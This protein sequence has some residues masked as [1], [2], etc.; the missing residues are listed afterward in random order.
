MRDEEE[1]RARFENRARR[2]SRN[3]PRG[4]FDFINSIRRK[5]LRHRRAFNSSLLHGIGDDAAVIEQ[6]GGFDTVVTADLLVEDVDFRL[7]TTTARHLGHKALAVSLSDIAAMGA[8]PRFAL[9]SVGVPRFIWQSKF[10]DEFY[11]G[12]FALAHHYRVGL[13]GGDVSRTPGRVVIDSI[14]IGEVEHGSAVTR[15]GAR[16]GDHIFVTGNLGGATAGLRLLENETAPGGRR[17]IER[18]IGRHRRPEPRLQWGALLGEERLATAMIDLSDGLS[19]DLAHLCRE[20]RV[21]ARIDAARIPVD[22]VVEHLAGE[23]RLHPL[24]AALGGGEDFELLF[25]IRP[26]DLSRLPLRLGNV[27]ATYIG[28][29]TTERDG[30]LLNQGRSLRRLTPRGFMHF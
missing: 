14:V 3:P 18:A 2:S 8:R 20:S 1:D 12:F 4:E 10:L 6:R 19:S 5:A 27:P 30:V 7:S 24:K 15:S 17:I 16:P 23:L 29:V 25:S 28:D 26:R 21:G 11:E 9:L 22:P 13:I